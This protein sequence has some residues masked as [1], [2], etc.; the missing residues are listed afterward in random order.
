[1]ISIYTK[2]IILVLLTEV[3]CS[4]NTIDFDSKRWKNWSENNESEWNMRWDMS[5]DLI[6]NVELKGKDTLE[7]FHLLGKESLNC[8]NNKC[9]IS[10]SLG[11][12]RRGIDYG[13][14]ELTFTNGK[15]SN[16]YRHCN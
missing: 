9:A 10:Y 11:P 16:I 7:I 8:F 1:M 6:N 4:C 3:I 2:L 14:L 12:C 13:T 5:E 15:V